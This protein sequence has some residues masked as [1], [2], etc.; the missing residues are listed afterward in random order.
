MREGLHRPDGLGTLCH[1]RKDDAGQKRG[2]HDPAK[3]DDPTSVRD[4]FND[5]GDY[6]DSC[7]NKQPIGNLS[8]RYR[9]F[10]AKPFHGFSP[11]R[12]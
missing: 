6:D 11:L 4:E 3:R 2:W 10:P 8:A 7:Q 9:C 1:A 12:T 5:N